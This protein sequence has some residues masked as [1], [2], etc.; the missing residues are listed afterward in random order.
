M[1]RDGFPDDL[2]T[3]VLYRKSLAIKEKQDDE[4]G[5]ALIYHQLGIIAQEQCDF[6]AAEQWFKKSLAIKEKQDDE[7]GAASTFNQ[8]GQLLRLQEDYVSA[9]AWYMKALLIF[10]RYKDQYRFNLVLENFIGAL[11]A[12]DPETQTLLRQK[13]QQAE[14]EQII[15]LAQLE[16]KFNEDN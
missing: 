10:L 5:V 2:K 16:Q 15:P 6:V 11:K 7:H 4:H 8:L 3:E 9:A 13:W 12:A 14:L 1:R